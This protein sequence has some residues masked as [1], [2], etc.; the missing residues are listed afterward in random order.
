MMNG[1]GR[2]WD[3][4]AKALAVIIAAGVIGLYIAREE[5]DDRVTTIEASR[6]TAQDGA[7]LQL[8]LANQLGDIREQLARI[9]EK[10]EQ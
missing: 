6:F 9:E 1:N 5:I 10:L 3:V 4:V 2:V 7:R 8:E